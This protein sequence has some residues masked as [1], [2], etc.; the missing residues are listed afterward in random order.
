MYATIVERKLRRIFDSLN[1]GDAAP[2]LAGLA[3]QFSYRFEGDAPIAGLRTTRAS[4]QLW[5]ARLYRLFPCFQFVIRE[6]A[7][8]GPPWRTRIHV[9]MDFVVPHAPDGPYKN[10][11]MQFMHMRWGKVTMIHTLED[12][13]R[14]GRYLAWRAAGGMAEA[15]AAPITDAPWPQAGP[16]LRA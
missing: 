8:L 1:Q 14:C 9:V 4:M 5:W 2:M 10:I 6:V 12:T 11:V 15:L 7:V 16:F 3:P 13:Q